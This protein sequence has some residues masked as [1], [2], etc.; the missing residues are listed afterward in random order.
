VGLPA[1]ASVLIV[2]LLDDLGYIDGAAPW[3][4]LLAFAAFEIVALGFRERM[5]EGTLPSERLR[6]ANFRRIVREA[7]HLAKEATRL[8]RKYGHRL[9]DEARVD[10]EDTLGA[11]RSSL[12]E[13]RKGPDA[14]DAIVKTFRRLDLKVEEHLA[15]ARKSTMREYAESIGVAVLVAL[16]LRAFV[17]EAFKIPSG[18][19]IPTLEVGDHIFVNKFIYGL[20]LPF[21]VTKFGQHIRE[22]R[23]G[24]V[25]V[26][27]YPGDR[28]K[29]FIKRIVG[30]EGDEIML[31][32]TQLYVN[33]RP[34]AHC[35][36]GPYELVDVEG[37][38][39]RVERE[40]ADLYV[41]RSGEFT[42]LTAY[43]RAQPDEEHGPWR[44]G[45]D[46]V[47]VMGD[48]RDNS[49]DSRFWGAVPLS[50]I[51]GR[52]LFVWWSNGGP[53]GI[54]WDRLGRWITGDPVSPGGLDGPI[55]D[56]MNDLD[57]RPVESR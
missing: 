48:N 11:L 37:P 50:Y 56:C 51:K 8:I 6:D 10:L 31:R 25:V 47:F 20:Q 14:R 26:F 9:E 2:M 36:V 17:V 4:F 44:V 1:L 16:F 15:F 19:M 28:S 57:G 29:D 42:Y 3:H 38:D 35:R 5:Q 32:G 55:G 49:H 22:P 40:P 54:R 43:A 12:R 27:V 30:I 34:V 33:R 7:K 41:E 52:A 53:G 45:R 21:T 13:R 39:R 24:E 46:R 23:R 18:S